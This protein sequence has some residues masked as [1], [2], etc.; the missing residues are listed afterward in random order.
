LTVDTPAL[1]SLHERHTTRTFRERL[2]RPALALASGTL[3]ALSMPPWG[4]WPL[5]IV[6]VVLFEV[7]LE[8]TPPGA[9]GSDWGCCSVPDGCTSGWAGWCS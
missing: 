5:A 1:Q 8:N 6:G 7:T 2:A 9:S 3:V 4:F